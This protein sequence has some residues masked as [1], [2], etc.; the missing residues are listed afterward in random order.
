MNPETTALILSGGNYSL[1][2]SPEARALKQA[3]LSASSDVMKVD[4][5]NESSTA[6]HHVR[7][8]ASLRILVE[9]SRKEVKAPVLETSRMIDQIANSF[10]AEILD[11]ETRI[12]NLM[13]DYAESVA[14]L[15]R[16]REIE[17]RKA[18]DAA[19]LA[20]ESAEAAQEVA[21]QSN[22][23]SDII[24]AKMA[25]EACQDALAAKFEASSE[26][27]AT[28]V[29]DGIRFVWDFE[30]ISIKDLQQ[31]APEF[32]KVEYKRREIL[33]WLKSL[34]ENEDRD[35]AAIASQ[36]GI[37]AYKIPSISTR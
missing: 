25:A 13:G 6:A 19:R 2:V 23:I 30:V 10:L 20:R 22:R 14:E 28:K 15:A 4:D 3:I 29:A 33:A 9:K 18:F 35:A 24:N 17:E 1:H 8:L 5:K 16:Q 21:E 31:G 36:I 34:E 27:A 12:K 7:K 11:E 26:L 37:L 32:V